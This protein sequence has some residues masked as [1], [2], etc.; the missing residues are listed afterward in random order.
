[1]QRNGSDIGGGG[2]GSGGR[3]RGNV[4]GM[5]KKEKRGRWS[6]EAGNRDERKGREG[7]EGS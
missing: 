6:G 3:V 4:H 7:E 5:K 1:M 2:G